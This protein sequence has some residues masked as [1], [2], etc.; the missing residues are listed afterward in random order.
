M[1]RRKLNVLQITFMKK[2]YQKNIEDELNFLKNI[3]NEKYH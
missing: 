1:N 2:N 3:T